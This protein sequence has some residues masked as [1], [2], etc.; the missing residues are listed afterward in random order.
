[1]QAHAIFQAITYAVCR[2]T[3]REWQ[4]NIRGSLR[5]FFVTGGS[6]IG[7]IGVITTDDN[8]ALWIIAGTQA[9]L[10]WCRPLSGPW[11]TRVILPDQFWTLLDSL[12]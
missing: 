11:Q 2:F 7:A 4:G 5:S 6:M 3:V 10:L 1:M 12:P 9:G 8:M